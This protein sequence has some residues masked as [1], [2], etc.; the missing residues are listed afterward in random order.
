M[1]VY[2]R[3]RS[4][5]SNSSLYFGF[6]RSTTMNVGIAIPAM[7][8]EKNIK[9]VLNRLKD[10]GYNNIL[11]IDGVSKDDTVKVAIENG[12]KIVLQEGAGKGN[13]I[14]QIFTNELQNVKTLVLMD[15]DGSMSA[16]EVPRFVRA[17]ENGVD[18]V[19]GSRFVSGGGS[20]DMTL[21]RR[22]GNSFLLA[23]VN[24]LCLT[25]YTDLCYGFAAF[26]RKAIRKL[27]PVLES[28]GF[29]I[30]AEIFIKAKKLGLKV[31]E[32]PSFE[33][34]R[35]YGQS[36]LKTLDDGLEIFKTIVRHSLR[37]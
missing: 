30:E 3:F 17:L 6:D 23:S 14:R 5:A 16:E 2:H 31:L 37:D 9:S 28:N 26:N 8:E 35:E 21:L 4:P 29:E 33:F 22:I 19:K 10:F 11:V 7:N 36:N 34:K 12:A 13:A 20:D 25:S 1:V 18:I 32:V 24:L 15:A 27:A